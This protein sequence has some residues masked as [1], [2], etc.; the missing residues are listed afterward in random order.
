MRNL[1]TVEIAHE[2]KFE[3][4]SIP[5][6]PTLVYYKID[7]VLPKSHRILICEKVIVIFE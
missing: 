1:N 2:Q 3:G 6:R 4:N 5:E 7:G